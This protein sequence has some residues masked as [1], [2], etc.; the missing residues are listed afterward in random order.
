LAAPGAE[1]ALELQLR[2]LGAW[3]RAMGHASP[4][5]SV[6]ERDGVTAAVVPACPER[7]IA[8]CVVYRDAESLGAALDGLADAYSE[9]GVRAWTVWVP[10]HDT[11]AVATLEAA[12]HVF[13]G[14][15]AAMHLDLPDLVAPPA[16][17]LDWDAEASAEEMG[18]VNDLAYGYEVG[19]GPGAAAGPGLPESPSRCYR[20]RIGDEVAC[21][22]QTIDVGED[23]FV[24][25]VATLE[26]HRG[27]R[28]ASR[29]LGTAL[30]EARARGL[31]TSTLESSML[32]RAVYERLG[33]RV[34]F[35]LKLYE[36]RA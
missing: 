23:C 6:F 33:Y 35:R 31:K 16:G 17:D 15:P 2:G 26:A 29:L 12:G 27:R 28:L 36:R 9:A 25:W 18:R 19:E 13:D 34:A 5:A 7:S 3:I 24:T 21:V 10:D 20:A 8:N 1:R 22:L 4:G 32:G 30:E 11:A 14:E